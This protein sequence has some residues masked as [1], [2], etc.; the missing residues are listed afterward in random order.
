M[1]GAVLDGYAGGRDTAPMAVGMTNEREQLLHYLDDTLRVP[2]VAGD[3]ILGAI[4]LADAG[5]RALMAAAI[6]GRLAEAARRFVAVYGALADRGQP[7]A[8]ALKSPLP[9]A[10]EWEALVEHLRGMSAPAILA[11]LRIDESAAVSAE[12]LVSSSDGLGRYTKLIRVHEV[13][14]LA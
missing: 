8:R 9:G 10:T 5:N 13:E 1:H 11:T 7:V 12:A 14:P 3:T 4:F 6:V 2:Q